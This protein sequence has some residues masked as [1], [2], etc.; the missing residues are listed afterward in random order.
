VEK[1][2]KIFSVPESITQVEQFVE[3]ITTQY[4]VNED[5]FGNILVTVT[6]G[7]N[8]AIIHGNKLN[9][10]KTVEVSALYV[11]DKS[12]LIFKIKDQGEGFDY[13]S[14]PDPTLPENIMK[15]SGRGVFIMRQ[16]ADMFYYS[17]KGTE[18]EMHFKL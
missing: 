8:N 5:I 11:E 13:D 16:L 3:D 7:A 10:D 12:T 2:L 15:S 18:V 14:L 17:D 9:K 1:T 6:E 4:D